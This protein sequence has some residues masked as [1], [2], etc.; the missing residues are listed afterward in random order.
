VESAAALPGSSKPWC[1]DLAATSSAAE[2]RAV[3]AGLAPSGLHERQT[4]GW[5][6]SLSSHATTATRSQDRRLR[7]AP[8]HCG[9][10]GFVS[11]PDA[12]AEPPLGAKAPA[13]ERRL[14]ASSI[15]LCSASKTPLGILSQSLRGR[16]VPSRNSRAQ[17]SAAAATTPAGP[18]SYAPTRW[19]SGGR[20]AA[21]FTGKSI[22]K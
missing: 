8:T 16:A 11:A 5:C 15:S 7:S 9:A 22:T 17:S 4:D 19:P 20:P 2:A 10:T 18:A 13:R 14:R 6:L 1:G 21:G 12:R 3:V